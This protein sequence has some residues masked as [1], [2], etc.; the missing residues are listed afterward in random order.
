MSLFKDFMMWLVGFN[1]AV[2]QVVDLKNLDLENLESPGFSH[3]L[4]TGEGRDAGRNP[5]SQ[6]LCFGKKATHW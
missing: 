3:K 2:H 5:F 1:S 6:A 4:K